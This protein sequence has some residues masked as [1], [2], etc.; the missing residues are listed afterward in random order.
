MMNF[1]GDLF[2]FHSRASFWASAYEF[3]GIPI[4]PEVND[5]P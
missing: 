2:G 4:L 5:P 1:Y 3:E